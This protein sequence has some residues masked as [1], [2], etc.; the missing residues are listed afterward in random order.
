MW[1]AEEGGGGGT[2]TTLRHGYMVHDLV[3]Q[4]M[5][6]SWKESMGSWMWRDTCSSRRVAVMVEWKRGYKEA[7]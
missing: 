5:E 4:E 2:K 1:L 7:P 3:A 6:V